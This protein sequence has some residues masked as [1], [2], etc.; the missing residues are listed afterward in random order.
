MPPL[1]P[2]KEHSQGQP[3]S[4]LDHSVQRHTPG[5]TSNQHE[6]RARVES[7]TTG[8]IQH[9]KS[10]PHPCLLGG[11]EVGGIAT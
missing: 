3:S 11:P 1:K 4:Y 7:S 6:P 9:Q 8:A 2:L 5:T 10:L